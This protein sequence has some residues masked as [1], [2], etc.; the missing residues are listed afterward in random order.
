MKKMPL[1]RADLNPTAAGHSKGVKAVAILR[2]AGSNIASSLG[3][4][5]KPLFSA[6][7]QARA[8]DQ[9]PSRIEFDISL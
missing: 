4:H 7:R 3:V 6:Q 8:E 5:W 2:N 9:I 1:R